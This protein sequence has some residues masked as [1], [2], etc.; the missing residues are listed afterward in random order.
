MVSNELQVRA[1]GAAAVEAT[2][3]QVW[4]PYII[5]ALRLAL[6]TLGVCITFFWTIFPYP[7]AEHTHLRNDIASAFYILANYYMAV[8]QTVMA[9]ISGTDGDLKDPKSPAAHLAKARQKMFRKYQALRGKA[10]GEFKFLDWEIGI[11]G[12]FPKQAYG[13]MITILGRLESYMTLIGYASRA[14][15]A[16]STTI[17]SWWDDDST[18][19]NQTPKAHL[20]PK[21]ITT[22]L[23]ILHSGL[24]RAQAL[25]PEMRRLRI[26]DLNDFLAREVSKED[27]F[28]VAALLH[29]V[30]WYLIKDLNSLTDLVLGLVGQLDFS[31]TLDSQT[32]NPLQVGSGNVLRA[33][34][35]EMWGKSNDDEKQ[36]GGSSNHSDKAMD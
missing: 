25:P 14:L 22:R 21:G 32:I 31:Y 6:V 27:G 16:Q 11:G 35:A 23:V 30:N 28:A 1:L 33:K 18:D 36:D 4:P 13:E 15:P 17:K 12:K 20:C 2:G 29:S 24:A 19:D 10:Q 9:R 7:V 8:Q 26:P 3:Q 34:K 5:F